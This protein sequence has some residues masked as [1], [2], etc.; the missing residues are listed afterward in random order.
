MLSYLEMDQVTWE[1]EGWAS[2]RIG[3]TY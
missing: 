2:T 1:C 3:K